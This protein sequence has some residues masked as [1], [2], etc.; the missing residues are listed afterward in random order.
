MKYKI[1]MIIALL[2]YGCS[3][4]EKVFEPKNLETELQIVVKGVKSEG[5]NVNVA[6]YDSKD[7]FL[8]AEKAI[9]LAYRKSYTPDMVFIVKGKLAPARYAILVFHDENGNGA[10]DTFKSGVPKE[11]VGSSNNPKGFPTW[12]TSNFL[13]LGKSKKVEVQ[14]AY[15]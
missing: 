3:S 10:L 9:I 7:R 2:V 6:V 15:P 8:K 11:G 12:E 1:I 5:G 13:V 4:A 14:I